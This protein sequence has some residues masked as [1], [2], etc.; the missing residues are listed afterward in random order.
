M[1]DVERRS[2][3]AGNG[4]NVAVGVVLIL[5]VGLGVVILIRGASTADSSRALEAPT[6]VTVS[7]AALPAEMSAM[8]HYAADHAEHFTTIPCYCGCDRSLG[9]R[10]L[11]DCFVTPAGEWDAHASG[12]GVCTVEAATAKELLESGADAAAVRRQI[13]DRYGPSPTTSSLSPATSGQGAQ[14]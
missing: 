11:K 6:V 13:I 14:P 2:D 3:R 1:N 5:L 7:L 9:H 4:W 12:C 10:N 8:Y